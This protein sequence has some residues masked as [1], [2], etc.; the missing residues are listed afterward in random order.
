MRQ[1]SSKTRSPLPAENELQTERKNRSCKRK[2]KRKK[3]RKRGRIIKLKKLIKNLE[4]KS[5]KANYLPVILPNYEITV[6]KTANPTTSTL[7]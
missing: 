4:K 1:K 6:Q 5:K 3:K 7:M 2:K